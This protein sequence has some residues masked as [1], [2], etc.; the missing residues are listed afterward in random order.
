MRVGGW[1]L[2]YAP[3]IDAF[4]HIYR[5]IRIYVCIYIY[6]YIYIPQDTLLAR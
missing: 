2:V 4:Y 3:E 1:V 5:Y 6:I